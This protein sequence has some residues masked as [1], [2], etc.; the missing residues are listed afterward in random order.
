MYVG[1]GN[2]TDAGANRARFYRTDDASGAARIRR[3]DDGPEHRLLHRPVLV[4]QRR[5]HAGRAHPMSSTSAGSFSYGELHGPVQ[6]TRLVVV[7]QWRSS[8]Q[9]SDSGRRPQPR[10]G[11]PS[12]RARDRHGSRQAAAV[13][14]RLGRRRRP[15]GRQVRRHLVQVRHARAQCRGPR[16]V[17]EPAEQRREPARQHEQRPVDAAV[18]E[19]VSERAAAAEPPPGRHAGQRDVPVQRLPGRLA[20]GDLRRRR[21]VR[22]QRRSTMRCASTRS[23][24]RRTTRTSATATRRSG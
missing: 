6:R 9:R 12:R 5:L 17:Q 23:P 18:P 1:V 11:N 14:H 13:H 20:A 21:P 4:R 24:A 19:P 8:I 16:V 3:H 2:Q 7:D 10:R 22:L 15:L